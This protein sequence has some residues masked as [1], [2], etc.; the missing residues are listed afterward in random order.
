MA[1]IHR[2]VNQLGVITIGKAISPAS[3]C[4]NKAKVSTRSIIVELER[5]ITIG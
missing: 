5:V 4:L 1:L 2:S 3:F